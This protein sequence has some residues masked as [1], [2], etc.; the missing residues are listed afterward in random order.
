MFKN[1][2]KT[3]TYKLIFFIFIFSAATKFLKEYTENYIGISDFEGTFNLNIIQISKKFFYSLIMTIIIL[4]IVQLKFI[5]WLFEF[6]FI[7]KFTGLKKLK[8][9][10]NK[11]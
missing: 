5:D 9:E 11:N 1:F 2:C 8:V 7:N 4:L 6:L 3:E 10:D